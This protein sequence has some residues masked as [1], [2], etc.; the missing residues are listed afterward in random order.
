M[1]SNFSR[2]VVR[3]SQTVRRYVRIDAFHSDT[4]YFAAYFCLAIYTLVTQNP[5]IPIT[6]R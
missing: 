4:F 6:T 3:F 1:L 2:S 5:L